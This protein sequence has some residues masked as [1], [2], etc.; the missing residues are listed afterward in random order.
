MKGFLLKFLLPVA[1]LTAF[2]SLL[3]ASGALPSP[4]TRA[5]SVILILLGF[6]LGFLLSSGDKKPFLYFGSVLL[7]TGFALLAIN[8]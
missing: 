7:I 3:T 5:L 1:L 6:F 8:P 4:A 2:F